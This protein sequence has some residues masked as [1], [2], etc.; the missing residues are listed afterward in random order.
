VHTDVR[1]DSIPAR[2]AAGLFNVV[3]DTPRGSRNKY[4]L[5]EKLGCYKLSRILPAGAVFPYDFGAVPGT[6]AED[7]DPVDVLVLMDAPSFP[8]CL[9]TV[10]LIGALR[11]V[12]VEN[13]RR[14]RNDRFVAVPQTPVNRAALRTLGDL[15]AVRLREIEHFFT[16]YNAAQGRTFRVTSRVGARAAQR[17]MLASLRRFE[18]TAG[19]PS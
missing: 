16:S 9:L 14:V 13:G 6:R 8:G 18:R 3:I 11:A 1:F 15:E 17:L 19:R 2:G 4:K 5:D 7:G 12:Q 10:R